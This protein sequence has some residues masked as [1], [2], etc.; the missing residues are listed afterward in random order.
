[1][2]SATFEGIDTYLSKKKPFKAQ[3]LFLGHTM[4]IQ[5]A[6]ISYHK[7]TIVQELFRHIYIQF[8]VNKLMLAMVPLSGQLK[9]E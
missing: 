9:S 7:R 1:M 8:T 4:N 6:L 5:N 2:V 3:A